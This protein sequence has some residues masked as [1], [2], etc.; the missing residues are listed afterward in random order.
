MKS[1]MLDTRSSLSF[2]SEFYFF[3]WAALDQ[4]KNWSRTE[5]IP[6]NKPCALCNIQN[7]LHKHYILSK[8]SWHVP[9]CFRSPPWKSIYTLQKSVNHPEKWL[10]SWSRHPIRIN[11]HR[12][13]NAVGRRLVVG[14]YGHSTYSI[15]PFKRATWNS[16]AFCVILSTRCIEQWLPCQIGLYSTVPSLIPRR[17][18]F[19]RKV[20]SL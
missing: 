19:V 13:N 17:L 1:I 20:A 9:N 11:I 12:H 6:S 7:I 5:I 10:T 8:N 3:R 4:W 18:P 14:F 15:R 2:M 16:L